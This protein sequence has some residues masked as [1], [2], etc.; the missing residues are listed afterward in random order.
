MRTGR[1]PIKPLTPEGK[2]HFYNKLMSRLAQD[3]HLTSQECRTLMR[4]KNLTPGDFAVVRDQFSFLISSEISHGKL[5]E[6]LANE[7]RYKN[8]VGKGIGF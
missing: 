8:S 7:V 3:R 4:I 6:A 5:I 2:L 1:W